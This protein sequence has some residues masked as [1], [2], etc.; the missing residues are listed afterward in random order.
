MST[1][2]IG[3]ISPRILSSPRLFCL[4]VGLAIAIVA[5][6]SA[7]LGEGVTTQEPMEARVMKLTP[8]L[9]VYIEKGMKAFDRMNATINDK[10]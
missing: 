5:Q 9:D 8:S 6:S 10:Y 1:Q 3:N 2:G 7:S 4:G